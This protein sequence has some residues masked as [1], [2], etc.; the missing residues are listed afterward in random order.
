MNIIL[1]TQDYPP[2]PGGM[3]RY[4]ADFA[5]GLGVRTTVFTGTWRGQTPRN[6]GDERV[7]A[8][9]FDAAQSHRWG[10][11]RLARQTLREEF[12]RTRP[13]LLIIGNARPFAPLGI[14]LGREFQVPVATV[15]HGNDLLRAAR[16]WKG[17]FLRRR[18]WKQLTELPVMHIMN[19][20]FT[21]SLATGLGFP[22]SRLVVAEPEVNTEL[23][24]PATSPESRA[25]I[26]ETFSLSSEGLYSLFVGRLVQRKG[27]DLLF[28]A[29]QHLNTKTTLLV[30]GVGDTTP[31]ET[32]ARENGVSDRVKF[33]GEIPEERLPDL[34]RAADIF[35]TPSKEI[36]DQDDV[37]GFG[38]VFLEAAASGVPSI[39]SR[40]GGIPEA[41]RED[42]SGLLVSPENVS[43]LTQAWERLLSEGETRT[44]LSQA[45][46]GWVVE[47]H[48]LGTTAAKVKAGAKRIAPA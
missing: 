22:E 18:L 47:N 3:A 7:V 4:Y 12:K 2:R 11:L 27:L 21:A 23:F 45:A 29:L 26:R 15:F 41:I 31:W 48:G 8:F 24:K 46:R 35:L 30:A 32:L 39:G 34:F 6:A 37:E 43:E 16:R 44:R 25:S 42:V 28:Q 38:I 20:R 19:S 10:H 9:P 5:S 40:S 13:Q 17:K 1:L 33:L 36:R 14:R